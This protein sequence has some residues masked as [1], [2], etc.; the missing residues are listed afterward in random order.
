MFL[1]ILIS[2]FFTFKAHSFTA[3]N[4][5]KSQPQFS[6]NRK[7]T[8]R[9]AVYV[10]DREC[11]TRMC[12]WVS[13]MT[14]PYLPITSAATWGKLYNW[15]LRFTKSLMMLK[16]QFHRIKI[17]QTFKLLSSLLFCIALC[18]NSYVK[19]VYFVSSEEILWLIKAPMVHNY[20][21]P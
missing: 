15:S 11:W 8:F 20:M 9:R 3:K 6:N 7:A 5:E 19:N 12:Y 10:M 1:K 21:G 17:P 16:S 2:L 13:S 4:K 14:L 18:T